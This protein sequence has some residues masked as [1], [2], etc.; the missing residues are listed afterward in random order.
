MTPRPLLVSLVLSGVALVVSVVV[1]VLVVFGGVLSPASEADLRPADY[2]PVWMQDD[3]RL[4][5]DC[6]HHNVL[7]DDEEA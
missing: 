5:V 2:Q 4:R 3:G 6:D 1:L 7:C